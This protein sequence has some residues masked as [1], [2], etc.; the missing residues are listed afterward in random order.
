MCRREE[1]NL[2]FS[3]A[4]IDGIIFHFCNATQAGQ[5]Q[6]FAVILEGYDKFYTE[7]LIEA[8]ENAQAG[9]HFDDYHHPDSLTDD[10]GITIAPPNV[11]I[12]SHNYHIPL[13][14]WKELMQEWLVFL[15]A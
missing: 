7:D 6:T 4:V 12:S 11:I 5:P 8:I 14:V 15:E 10:F 2:T 1:Y 9:Q 3:K 13:Q